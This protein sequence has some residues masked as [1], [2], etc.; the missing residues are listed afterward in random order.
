MHYLYVGY[1]VED[2][3][4]TE[5]LNRKINNMSVA[6]QKF[7]YNVI[8]G[9]H[10][11]LG[12]NVSFVSYVP[13]DG[14]LKI[15]DTSVVQGASVTHIAIN[16]SSAVSIFAAYGALKKYLMS[17]G[18]EKLRGL[19]I[20]MYAVIPPFEQALLALK[21][22]YGFKIVTI[23]SEIPELRRY[24]SSI[25]SRIKKKILTH[26]NEQFDGYVL[27]SDAMKEVVR[28][29]NKPCLVMEG[30]GPDI[31]SV[32][33]A[34]KKNIVMYAGG[35]AP[36]NNIPLLIKCCQQIDIIDE[37]WICGVGPDENRIKEMA[38]K[39]ARVK[40]F[41]RVP[42]E[43]VLEMESQAKV[44]VNFRNPDERL[45]R[46]SFPSKIL[47]YISS[48]SL[49]MSTQLIG[50]PKE[51]FEYIV[52]ISIEDEDMIAY[53]LKKSL[54]MSDE[55]YLSKCKR[56]QMFMANNKNYNIQAERLVG[57]VTDV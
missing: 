33:V 5:I 38:A 27:F 43:E 57:F 10:E 32:P 30:I 36:D 19:H 12:D 47:E 15:P 29:G 11:Q 55:D 31:R 20:V 56:A 22:R 17:L 46:Y 54:N 1:Y 21:K 49:V 41:G 7:E 45:T 42:N 52:P 23:C 40:Y 44:L 18:E 50:I 16:K 37:I 28:V 13:T 39:D 35:L 14:N 8:R 6:R 2:Q 53:E 9:M 3:T 4:F 34:G 26:Y 24:G 48:G 51:Y 25:P